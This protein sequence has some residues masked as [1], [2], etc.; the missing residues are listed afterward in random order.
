[1]RKQTTYQVQP[2][3]QDGSYR[4]FDYQTPPPVQTGKRVHVSGDTLSASRSIGLFSREPVPR[5]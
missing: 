5:N 4:N 1:M 3:M 2:R